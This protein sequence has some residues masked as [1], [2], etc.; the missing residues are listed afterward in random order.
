MHPDI[1]LPVELAHNHELTKHEILIPPTP[2][3]RSAYRRSRTFV[4]PTAGPIGRKR[5]FY[6]SLIWTMKIIFA[7]LATLA[8]F[9]AA[10][11]QIYKMHVA[12]VLANGPVYAN[13]TAC[14]VPA[15]ESR[16]L[17]PDG[18][19]FLGMSIDWAVDT[20]SKLQ[21]RLGFQPACVGTFIK[22]KSDSYESDMLFW[23]AQLMRDQARAIG[24]S[25]SMLQVIL[26][27]NTTLES[28]QPALFTKIAQDLRRV[29]YDYGVPVLLRFAHEM[30]GNWNFYGQ[31]P[32]QY[33]RTWIELTNA[34]RNATNLTA[35][36]W[37]PN[38]GQVSHAL[39]LHYS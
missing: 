4:Q 31:R 25:P 23:N 26:M 10:S 24:N 1:A 17:P 8:I 20:P 29:N 3:P 15:G 13:T 21:A 5:K 14:R 32:L 38:M 6:R 27:P 22:L 2:E 18:P 16:L 11:Y 36:M 39:Q 19:P 34:I 7:L 35:T 33:K 9:G 12:A 37:A 28:I 30:N